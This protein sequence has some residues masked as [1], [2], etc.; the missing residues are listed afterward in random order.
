MMDLLLYC[1]MVVVKR[2]VFSPS[3]IR[4]RFISTDGISA[5][6]IGL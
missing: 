6:T 5:S 1:S 2:C 4:P 3:S